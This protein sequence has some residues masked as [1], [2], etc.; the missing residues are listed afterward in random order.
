MEKFRV[1]QIIN[2]D[3]IMVTPQW[4]I[5]L[6]NGDSLQGN[7]LRIHGYTPPVRGTHSYT[8]TISKLNTLLM[9]KLVDLVNPYILPPNENDVAP[10]ACQVFI[11]DIEVSNYFSELK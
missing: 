10:I 7:K 3:T 5:T 1:I 9:G 8:L 4:R 2:S 11:D 6:K